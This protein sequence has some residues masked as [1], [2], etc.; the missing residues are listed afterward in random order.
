VISGLVTGAKKP[1]APEYSGQWP[2]NWVDNPDMNT[3]PAGAK[4]T[5]AGVIKTFGNG[6]W[7]SDGEYK[8]VSFS[9]SGVDASKYLRLRGSNLPAS[10]PYETDANGN[11]LAD[12]YTNA[13]D[14]SKLR[15]PCTT[16]LTTAI[17]ANTVYTGT[18]IDGCP[19]HLAR[20]PA[21]TGQQ[22]VSYDV[23][24]WS[25]LWFYSNPIFIEVKNAVAVKKDVVVAS[26]N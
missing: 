26:A 14:P 12:L 13:S 15:I 16:P 25:D 8:V 18:S 3:V 17:P 7:Q 5:S 22:Y 23:A 11:P 9:L 2:D 19:A 10:V 1:S 21:V 20:F 6:T 24:A 4:N